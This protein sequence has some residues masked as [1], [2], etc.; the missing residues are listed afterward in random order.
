M[1]DPFILD[2][3]VGIPQ[4]NVRSPVKRTEDT[5]LDSIKIRLL[6]GNYPIDFSRKSHR[7][8]IL[9]EIY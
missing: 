9:R 3:L 8:K 4:Q 2:H 1:G 5:G 7:V 6:D